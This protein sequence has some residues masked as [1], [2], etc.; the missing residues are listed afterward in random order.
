MQIKSLYFLACAASLVGLTGC[1]GGDKEDSGLGGLDDTAL[2]SLPDSPVDQ[3]LALSG[4]A[5][6]GEGDYTARCS[7]CHGIDGM[8]VS[9]PSLFDVV[10]PLSGEELVEVILYGTD[11]GMPGYEGQLT[12]QAFADVVAYLTTTYGG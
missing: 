8:G 1:D 3:I 10:P 12:N 5:S 6:L 9:A 4:D 11:Y 2:T 7:G